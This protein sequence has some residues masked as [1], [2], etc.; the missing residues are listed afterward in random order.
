MNFLATTYYIVIALY[1]YYI[2]NRPW[3]IFASGDWFDRARGD[4]AAGHAMLSPCQRGAD[5]A[6]HPAWRGKPD[7]KF[8]PQAPSLSQVLH[9]HS[10]AHRSILHLALHRSHICRLWICFC[11]P[12]PSFV[13]NNMLHPRRKDNPLPIHGSSWYFIFFQ[14]LLYEQILCLRSI[15]N[16]L[17]NPTEKVDIRRSQST[18]HTP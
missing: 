9:T 17:S 18:D 12:H 11:W 15:A 2:N 7:F 16:Y 4:G 8:T 10:R 5:W 14:K 1:K 6:G 13:W 3:T